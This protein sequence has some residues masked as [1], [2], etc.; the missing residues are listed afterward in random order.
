VKGIVF[1]G[2]T[3]TFEVSQLTP[4]HKSARKAAQALFLIE[5]TRRL[6]QQELLKLEELDI[7]CAFFI[8]YIRLW[9]FS[10]EEFEELGAAKEVVEEFSEQ[11]ERIYR[12]CGM[13]IRF[14]VCFGSSLGKQAALSTRTYRKASVKN[15]QSLQQEESTQYLLK[16]EQ[17][18]NFFL[19]DRV[20]FFH[21]NI[22]EPNMI[23]R[24]VTFIM[25]SFSLSFLTFDFNT[26]Q[27]D[28]KLTEF[29][30][31]QS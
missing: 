6:Q 17:T 9:N 4:L 1:C 12:A 7:S 13:P 3:I 22:P 27:G 26:L 2:G 19:S 21:S 31:R 25:N 24:E 29:L 10:L 5:R 28:V 11:Q 18:N 14:E 16:R 8:D 30:G 23:F 15:V 20:R